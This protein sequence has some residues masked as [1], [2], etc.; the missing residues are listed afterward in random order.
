[1]PNTGPQF[2]SK[3]KPTPETTTKQTQ[4][5]TSAKLDWCDLLMADHQ[6]DA[7]AKVVGFCIM[8]AINEESGHWKISD[9]TIA[10]KTGIPKRWVQRARSALLQR[11]W[12][13]WKRTRDANIYWLLNDRTGEVRDHQR[14]LKA[15]RDAKRSRTKA[16]RESPQ[17]ADL[18]SSGFATG[19][20]PDSPRVA[21]LDSPRVANRHLCSYTF[22]NTFDD[23]RTR[24]IRLKKRSTPNLQPLSDELTLSPEMMVF[25]LKHGLDL[26]RINRLFDKFKWHHRSKGNQYADW[27]AAWNVWVL[28]QVEFD[29]RAAKEDATQGN[30]L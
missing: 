11:G 9:E 3:S 20:G 17:V 8:Q 26:N 15:A 22:D 21:V 23:E 16:T 2:K 7:R 18:N 27:T 6:L 12:I 4:S 28:N 19:G 24:S 10:D 30:F 14:E 13:T 5:F 25:A 1:M 29:A